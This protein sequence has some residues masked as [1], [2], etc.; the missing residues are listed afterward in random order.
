MDKKEAEELYQ[1]LKQCI[2][3]KAFKEHVFDLFHAVQAIRSGEE[4]YADTHQS[5]AYLVALGW[6]RTE[7][8]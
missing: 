6:H 3:D 7:T 1:L 5:K 8:K 4:W 2:H